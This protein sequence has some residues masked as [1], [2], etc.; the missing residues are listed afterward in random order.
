MATTKT[1]Q[2]DFFNAII[3]VLNGRETE[4]PTAD[5]VTFVKGRIEQL[6]R[7]QSKV[8]GKVAEKRAENE[9]LKA[10]LVD[11]L[12]AEPLCIADIKKFDEFGG[13]ETSKISALLTQLRNV[14]LVE[15]T[16]VKGKPFYQTI[17]EEV[18]EN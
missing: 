12:S 14:G 18:A 2:K 6:N 5:L 7:K 16:V 1:T 3:A 10:R 15:R 8:S 17:S 11:I 9:V 4:I 13:F